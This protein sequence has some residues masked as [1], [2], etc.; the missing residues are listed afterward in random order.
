[1]KKLSVAELSKL[2]GISRQSIYSHIKK[3]SLSKGSDGL[4]DFSEA[5]RAFGEPKNK[6][7]VVKQSLSIDS[8][9]LTEVDMLKRQVDM[10]EK[11]LHQANI[12]ENKSVERELFYQEQIEA[13]QRLLEAPKEN[14]TTF[15]GQETK[16]DTKSENL[17]ESSNTL[18]SERLEPQKKKKGFWGKLF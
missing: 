6:E 11:Q 16:P 18:V 3:G 17:T 5:I 13:M 15:A 9:Q 4:V 2:Y 10:L 7:H 8:Q 14:I 1:M 12:R